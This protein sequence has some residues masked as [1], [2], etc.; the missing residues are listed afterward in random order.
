MTTSCDCPEKNCKKQIWT[1]DLPAIYPDLPA[2]HLESPSSPDPEVEEVAA[3]RD[4]GNL[5]KVIEPDDNNLSQAALAGSQNSDVDAG[6]ISQGDHSQSAA[7]GSQSPELIIIDDDDN[8]THLPPRKRRS[9]FGPTGISFA[10]KVLTDAFR[11]KPPAPTSKPENVPQ[12]EEPALTPQAMQVDKFESSKPPAND[13]RGGLSLLADAAFRDI[14]DHMCQQKELVAESLRDARE[15]YH[16][17]TDLLALKMAKINFGSEDLDEMSNALR[18]LASLNR[19]FRYANVELGY[20][21]VM[22]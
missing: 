15:T 19:A 11:P 18:A 2:E 20:L 14:P 16:F 7:G 17:L 10:A 1:G 6:S 5:S 9:M 8:Q 21:T 3:G 13:P 22:K 12:R 4:V